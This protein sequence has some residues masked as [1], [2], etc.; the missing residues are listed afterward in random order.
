M[1]STSRLF[2]DKANSFVLIMILGGTFVYLLLKIIWWGGERFCVYARVFIFLFLVFMFTAVLVP[3]M[4]LF[5]KYEPLKDGD[6]KYRI[7]GLRR[8]PGSKVRCCF[9]SAG[10]SGHPKGRCT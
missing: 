4:P 7:Y 2:A 9:N 10:G 8:S 3:I 6:T 5:N 1:V